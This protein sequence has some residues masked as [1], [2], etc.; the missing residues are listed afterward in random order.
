ML[1]V[2]HNIVIVG[3]GSAGWMTAAFLKKTFPNKVI[4]VIESKEVPIVGVGES[5]LADITNFR[6]YLGIDE[7]EF[8]RATDASYKMSIKFTDFYLKDSGGFH[9]PFRS[10]YLK[11]T[12]NGLADWMEIKA[13][14]PETPVQDFVRSYFPHAAL[15]ETNKYNTNSNGEFNN[16]YPRS[17]VAYHF[18]AVKFGNWLKEKYCKPLGVHHIQATVK[19][20]SLNENGIEY[21][22]L[23]DG[24]LVGA[25]LFIDC[26]GFKSLL[27]GEYLKEPFISFEDLLPNNRA[28]ATQLPYVDKEL[29]LEPFTNGTAIENGWC[30]NI[31]LWSRLGTGYVYSDK[32]VSPEEALEQFKNY[33]L[34]SKTA[35]NSGVKP[36]RNI[37]DLENLTFKDIKMRVGMHEKIW[38]KN[39]VAIGLSAGFIEPLE[40][41]GLFS[42][43]GFLYKLGHILKRDHASQ[44][45]K[46]LFNT[47]CWQ[48][49]DNFS[50]FVALHYALSHRSDT[51]YWKDISQ[52]TFSKS[53]ADKSEVRTVG[54]YDLFHRKML[55][56]EIAPL[57]GITYV[58]V[59]MNFFIFDSIDQRLN[60]FGDNL[61]DYILD[62]VSKF[63]EKKKMWKEAAELSPTLY[64]Y[65]KNNI[66]D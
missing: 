19:G 26:T 50:Q 39:V 31:P 48:I 46:D 21:L 58:S 59:G 49:F 66:H 18:D 35:A 40:S 22:T 7:K 6:D 27:L 51:Q 37:K 28:W 36:K 61:S 42:V 41:N 65:L 10:P 60:T 38:V 57:A 64:E 52:K 11:E 3:G 14:F 24:S 13:Y 33:L 25:D 63:E 1:Q 56:K 47:G 20:A 17:D 29:E 55:S 30:W 45:D 43:T 15:F 32:H 4:T 54:F 23:D 53:L 8:M 16:F 9:Y 34:S 2:L 12:K 44:F 5:T 62:S